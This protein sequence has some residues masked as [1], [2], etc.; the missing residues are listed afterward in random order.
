MLTKV[1]IIDNSG[2]IYGRIIKILNKKSSLNV[3]TI[4][5]ISILSNIP[6]SKI[7]KGQMHKALIVKDNTNQ[8][9]NNIKCERHVILVKTKKNEIL[10]IGSRIKGFISAKIKNIEGTQRVLAITKRTL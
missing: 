2:A 7:R 8:F 9:F 10:P 4:V 6:N 5:L 1:K 3:G